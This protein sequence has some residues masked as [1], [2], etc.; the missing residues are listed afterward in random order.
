MTC[1]VVAA[2][3]FVVSMVSVAFGESTVTGLG[4]EGVVTATK[5]NVRVRPGTRYSKVAMLPKGAKVRVVSYKDGWYEIVAPSVSAVWISAELVKDG[6]VVKRANLRAGPSVAFS[7]YYKMAEPGEKI[8]VVDSTQKSWLKISPPRGLTAWTSADYVRVNPKD[9]AKLLGK[10]RLADKGKGGKATVAGKNSADKSG[11]APADK[12]S[13]DKKAVGGAEAA[14][15]RTEKPPLPFLGEGSVVEIEGV[16]FPV[17]S[18]SPYVTHTVAVEV[19]GEPFPLCYLHVG[20]IDITPLEKREVVV[21]GRQR[22]V[23]GWR[24]PVMDVMKIKLVSELG[25]DDGKDKDP[26]GKENLDT[27]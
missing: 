18:E 2:F 17:K 12:T 27:Q 9:S 11:D 20:D 24:R 16:L 6:F 26:E 5:L 4:V 10:K 7:A 14:K 21:K 25:K 22:F 8:V 23:R 15:S 19:N 3:V 13:G 1:K